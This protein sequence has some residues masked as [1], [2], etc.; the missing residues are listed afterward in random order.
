MDYAA[1]TSNS[2]NLLTLV[3]D[4]LGEGGTSSSSGFVV[5]VTWF[6]TGRVNDLVDALY[7][8]CRVSAATA[9]NFYE[10]T[11]SRIRLESYN[12]G[13]RVCLIVPYIEGTFPPRSLSGRCVCLSCLNEL[14]YSDATR[15]AE[16]LRRLWETT[17]ASVVLTTDSRPYHSGNNGS[18]LGNV[19]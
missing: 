5:E 7:V 13:R 19:P 3:S 18:S 1:V 12:I 10:G 8:P 6:N 4:V 17:I 14:D 9:R 2:N 11:S 15:M 16:T